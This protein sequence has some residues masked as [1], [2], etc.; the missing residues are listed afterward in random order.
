MRRRQRRL[1][2]LPAVDPHLTLS[3]VPCSVLVC[4]QSVPAEKGEKG[5]KERKKRRKEGRKEET[6]AMSM[7]VQ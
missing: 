1:H 6:R 5:L 7:K 3:E 4:L 2:L